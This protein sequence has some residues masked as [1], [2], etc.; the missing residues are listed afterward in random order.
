VRNRGWLGSCWSM[1]STTT[2]GQ[3]QDVLCHLKGRIFTSVAKDSFFILRP[4]KM[5]GRPVAACYA[6]PVRMCAI[7]APYWSVS[8][9]SFEHPGSSQGGSVSRWLYEPCHSASLHIQL[10]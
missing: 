1:M 2:F 5:I 4:V 3:A 7:V 10:P 6:I 8:Q 9:K